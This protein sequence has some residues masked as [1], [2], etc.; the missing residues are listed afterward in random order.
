MCVLAF[1]CP[2]YAHRRLAKRYPDP[3]SMGHKS[4]WSRGE[5]AA[6][7]LVIV[8]DFVSVLPVAEE[9]GRRVVGPHPLERPDKLIRRIKRG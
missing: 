8:S 4:A 9:A 7:D 3:D 6:R 5:R 1:L 2:A